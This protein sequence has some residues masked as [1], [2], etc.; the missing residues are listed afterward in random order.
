MAAKV[1][2][3]KKHF[4]DRAVQGTLL[5]HVV[6]YWVF[7]LFA[8]GVLVLFVEMLAGD[9]RDAAKNLLPRHGPTVLAVLALAPIFL[10]DL[11]KLSNR[12]AGPIV[13]LQRAMRDLAEG[14]EVSPIHFRE[15]DFWQDLASDFNQ[16]VERVQSSNKALYEEQVHA[17]SA[18][19]GSARE[20]ASQESTQ[21]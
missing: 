21:C 15:H 18:D 17:N 16:V 1:N 6:A 3:R 13:R 8:A 11:C 7:F 14:R 20:L 12:F 10:R 2:N 4:V 19:S 9:P 5:I